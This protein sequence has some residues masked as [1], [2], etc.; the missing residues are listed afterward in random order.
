MRRAHG[1]V[2]SFR[3]HLASKL[4]E[5]RVDRRDLVVFGHGDTMVAIPNEVRLAD[6]VEA[7]RMRG[8]PTYGRPP[9]AAREHAVLPQPRVQTCV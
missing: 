7:H 6:L 1:T 9:M 8:A 3:A 5:L 2:H 4:H